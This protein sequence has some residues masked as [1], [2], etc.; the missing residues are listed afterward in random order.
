MQ[1]FSCKAATAIEIGS[2]EIKEG[3]MKI[4]YWIASEEN[5]TTPRHATPRPQS[6]VTSHAH[7][8]RGL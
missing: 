3:K 4:T 7:T 8:A 5:S 1:R 2:M 6:K